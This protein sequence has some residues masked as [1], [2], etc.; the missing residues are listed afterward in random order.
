MSIPKHIN[1]Q[2]QLVKLINNKIENTDTEEDHNQDLDN[3]F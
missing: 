2:Q 1:I 3:G